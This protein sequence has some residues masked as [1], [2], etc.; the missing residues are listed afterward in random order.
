MP[1]TTGVSKSCSNGRRPKV[2]KARFWLGALALLILCGGCKKEQEPRAQTHWGE[3]S[4]ATV[5]LQQAARAGTDK[6][7]PLVR[8]AKTL[9]NFARN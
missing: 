8:I 3:P 2:K 7:A 9:V 1:Y 4:E 6:I 5:L